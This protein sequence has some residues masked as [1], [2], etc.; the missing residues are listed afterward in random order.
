MVRNP[1]L[2]NFSVERNWKTSNRISFNFKPE[3]F[4]S[5]VGKSRPWLALKEASLIT[6]LP[7]VA[8]FLRN[9]L[10]RENPHKNR[11]S[12]RFNSTML[13]SDEELLFWMSSFEA[14]GQSFPFIF[15][16]T[17]SSASACKITGQDSSKHGCNFEEAIGEWSPSRNRF[18][19]K[20]CPTRMR[21]QSYRY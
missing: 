12:S 10:R 3:G 2:E 18:H 5:L 20:K 19:C 15:T 4:P 1:P 9:R 21:M 17:A 14:S 8:S 7:T 16:G 13:Y 11:K 6:C